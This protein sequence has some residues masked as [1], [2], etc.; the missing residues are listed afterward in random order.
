MSALAIPKPASF[1]ATTPAQMQEAQGAMIQWCDQRVEDQKVEIAEL[2]RTIG[3]AQR[4]SM[5]VVTWKGRLALAR[6]KMTFYRKVKAALLKGFYIVPPFPVKIFAIRVGSETEPQNTV[7]KH[8]WDIDR[9][10]KGKSLEGGE[11]RWVNPIPEINTWTESD[12]KD[13]KI[14]TERYFEPGNWRDVNFPFKMVKPEIIAAVRG[15]MEDK[16]F[17]TLGVLPEYKTPDPIVMG[18][19][20]PPHRKNDPLC[21]FIAWWMDPK[22][23]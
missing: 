19:I 15:A 22:D 4:V 6:R 8:R 9:A 14:V 20:I 13:G 17:D 21:F 12:T 16:I 10:Q 18:Q 2:E 7:S 5:N 23:L 3:E 1:I 11:G